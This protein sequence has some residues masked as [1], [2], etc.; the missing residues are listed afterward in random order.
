MLRPESRTTVPFELHFSGKNG[1]DAD[2]ARA[3]NDF[4][5][6][7]A[8]VPDPGRDLRLS[9]QDACRGRSAAQPWLTLGAA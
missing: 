2:R 7:C 9:K 4:A 8:G 3:L 5:L 1:D 6:H